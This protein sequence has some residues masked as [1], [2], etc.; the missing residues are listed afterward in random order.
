MSDFVGSF[1]GWAKLPLGWVLGGMCNFAQ[2]EISYVKSSKLHSLI[3]VLSHLL[4]V[5][6][7]L[8][9]CFV[10]GFVQVIQVDS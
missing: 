10:S 3:V 6:R 1:L 5:L 4:L 2:D 8:T 9:G 7:H